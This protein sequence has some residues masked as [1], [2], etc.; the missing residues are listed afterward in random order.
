MKKRDCFVDA[1]RGYACLAVVFYHVIMGI[2]LAGIEYPSTYLELWIENFL[3]SFH[4]PLFM[5][6]SGYVF[7]LT[8]GWKSKGTRTK[9]ILH[10]LLNLGLPYAFFSIVYILIN[11]FTPGTNHSNSLSDMLH[12][13]HRPVAQYW[14]LF[15]LLLLFIIWVFLS[16][17]INDKLILVLM[18]FVNMAVVL[19]D[20][21][22]FCWNY[23][24]DFFVVFGLGVILSELYVDKLNIAVK[25]LIL[26]MHVAVVT[27]VFNYDLVSLF[28]VGEIRR[29]VG[30]TASIV[31]ISLLKHFDIIN[32]LLLVVN[33]YSF[34]IYLLHTIFTSATRIV[35]K[36]IGL[37][38]SI[39]HSILGIIV[40]IVIPMIIANIT[41]KIYPLDF[42]FYPSKTIKKI[43]ASKQ[44]YNGNVLVENN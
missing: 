40:G 35:L 21:K 38:N 41:S 18:V 15:S 39:I 5:F 22:V 4:V 2:R 43:K 23:V 9:F 32:K 28:Y 7:R 31:L 13:W 17:F 44:K 8:G 16:N 14:F 27:I 19:L 42:F 12:I 25:I 20:A 33:K 6:L 26:L 37:N 11:H 3:G 29:L 24:G 30:V 36:K 10:K 1:L 34:P